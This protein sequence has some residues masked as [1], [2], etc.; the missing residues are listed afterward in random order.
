[1][2]IYLWDPYRSI[3]PKLTLDDLLQL[4]S[5]CPALPQ[6]LAMG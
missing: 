2:R 4:E 6:Y 1:V 5:E 3:A